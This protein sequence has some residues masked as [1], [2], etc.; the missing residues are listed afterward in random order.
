MTSLLETQRTIQESVLSRDPRAAAPIIV[1][2]DRDALKA[3]LDIYANGYVSRLTDVLRNDFGGLLRL[4]GEQVF[5]EIAASYIE[6]H[7]SRTFNA[8]WFGADLAAFLKR[9]SAWANTPWMGD[10]AELDWAIGLAFDAP[11]EPRL[12]SEDL[13]NEAPEAWPSMCFRLSRSVQRLRL[14][15]NVG[16]IRRAADN[17]DALPELDRL[18]PKQDWVVSRVGSRI[19]HRAAAEDEAEA[20]GAVAQGKNF[21]EVCDRLSE[22]HPADAVIPRAASMLKGWIESGWLVRA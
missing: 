21:A 3:R 22:W 9:S 8:R 11:D 2:A 19:F 7:P 20:L 18:S 6:A 4:A 16:D 12:S 1:S 13:Q 10:M 5:A 15:W 14:G 17:E